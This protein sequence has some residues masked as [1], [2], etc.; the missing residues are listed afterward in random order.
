MTS[1]DVQPRPKGRRAIL[2]SLLVASTSLGACAVSGLGP[3]PTLKGADTFASTQ[4]F[5]A[6]AAE[7]P[8]DEWWKTYG[9][10]Q[11]SGLID[12]A[13][14]NSPSMAA[15]EARVRRAEALRGLANAALRPEI[16]GQVMVN[17]AKVD[18]G[19]LAP[20]GGE[21][22]SLVPSGI[23]TAG[24]ALLNG[25]YDFDLW[26]RSRAQLSAASGEAE[27]ARA[28][29]AQARLTLSTAVASAYADLA[30][31]YALL[32]AATQAEETRR[33][34]AE[35]I[36]QRQVNGL[37]NRGSVSQATAGLA[38]AQAE[39]AA[40]E[41]AVGLTKNRIAALLGAG[42][43]RG[44]AIQAP[45]QAAV[46]GFGLPSALQADL[47]GR[48]PDI[49]AARLRAEAAGE[50]VKAAK[51]GFYPNV[52][53]S[54]MAGAALLDLA[55]PGAP[56]LFAAAGPALTLPMFGGGRIE[57]QIRQ[58]RAEY[59]AAVADYNRVVTEA[60]QQVADVATSERAL[61]QRLERSQAALTASEDAYRVANERYQGG[62]SNLIDVLRAEDVVI[63]NRRAVA[64]LQ[65]RAFVLD[66]ALIR[67][68]GGGYGA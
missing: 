50:R 33:K 7:W 36:S 10:A 29:A 64:D 2:A 16:G 17:A 14:A 32:H 66:I 35:L 26:G 24:V 63:A 11:L 23:S 8:K 34:T 55:A 61:A 12:E 20:S 27:A 22:E 5:S 59:D 4:S 60:F 18:L 38:Q 62:L 42:P 43:D 3:E 6:P 48:R 41:E 31:Q 1:T 67:A 40:A 13:L 51:T 65:T 57:N 46:K 68:L 52:N 49:V 21:G 28:D 25:G 45:P 9:D 37:E 58:S 19:D 44:L 30:Q 53:L 54:V 39:R 15:A 56:L 47:V